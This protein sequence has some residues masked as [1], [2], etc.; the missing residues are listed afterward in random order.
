MPESGLHYAAVTMLL[1][2]RG[3]PW[4][5]V[6]AGMGGESSRLSDKAEP[7]SRS[8]LSPGHW[9]WGR[10]FVNRALCVDSKI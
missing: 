9:G 3:P 10:V 8:E 7:W 4:P 5:R 2:H 6:E 1:G